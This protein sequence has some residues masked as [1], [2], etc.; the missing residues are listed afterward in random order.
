M[1]RGPNLEGYDLASAWAQKP[2]SHACEAA[3]QRV[4]V[5]VPVVRWR[6]GDGRVVAVKF[7]CVFLADVKGL[8]GADAVAKAKNMQ[9]MSMVLYLFNTYA[10]N[11]KAFFK[12]EVLDPA[13]SG[14]MYA[15][16]SP[17]NAQYLQ[18]LAEMNTR[19]RRDIIRRDN[20]SPR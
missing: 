17:G 4:V 11:D 2:A 10:D 15:A 19:T 12:R 1:G 14:A 16:Q 18:V 3:A 9:V 7:L 5:L 20:N 13:R 8:L 6:G